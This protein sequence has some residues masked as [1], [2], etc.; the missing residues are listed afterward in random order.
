MLAHHAG[1]HGGLVGDPVGEHRGVVRPVEHG[2]GIVAHPAVHG[3]VAALHTLLDRHGLDGAHGVHRAARGPRDV[4][5]GLEGQVRCRQRG[6]L[7]DGREQGGEV[8]RDLLDTARGVRGGVGDP[9]SSAEVHLGQHHVPAGGHGL[10]QRQDALGR[11]GESLGREDLGA[12]VAVQTAQV[13]GVGGVEARGHRLQGRG[14]L[15]LRAGGERETELLV[16]VRRGD[17]LVRGG[18][19]PRGHADHHGGPGAELPRERG[20]QLDLREGVHHDAP[21]TGAQRG[22]DL[23]GGLVVAVQGDALTGNPGCECNGQL[24]TGGGVDAESLGQCP[25]GHRRG[26]QGLGRVVHGHVHPER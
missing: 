25:A 21:H 5:T 20:H 14:V 3:D 26:E 23:R 15:A 16:L 12:D 11:L 19:H 8:R 7:Q 1:Q 10:P 9:V 2:T 18:V 17:E 13:Q 6:G 4:S 24:P 22:G